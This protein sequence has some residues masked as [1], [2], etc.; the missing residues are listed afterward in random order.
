MKNLNESK[1][2]FWQ[3]IYKL[4]AELIYPGNYNP[5]TVKKI[6]SHCVAGYGLKFFYANNRLAFDN[7]FQV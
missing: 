5:V 4:K 6:L 3:I 2:I 1:R 7:Y